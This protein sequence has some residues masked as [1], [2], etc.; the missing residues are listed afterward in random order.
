MFPL[1]LNSLQTSVGMKA[2]SLF[3]IE[4]GDFIT[5][6]FTAAVQYCLL[7]SSDGKIGKYEREEQRM[8]VIT[9]DW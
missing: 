6:I 9:A 3:K 7:W 8:C 2:E 4:A 1:Q 5:V